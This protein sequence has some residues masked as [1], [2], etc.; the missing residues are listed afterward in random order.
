MV[1]V[2]RPMLGIAAIVSMVLG[3]LAF[4]RGQPG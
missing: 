2:V 3:F 1:D 4:T